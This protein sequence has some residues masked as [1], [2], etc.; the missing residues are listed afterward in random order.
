MKPIITATVPT[1]YQLRSLSAFGI[2][3]KKNG[4]G[5]YSGKMESDSREE[6]ASLHFVEPG[7]H[8]RRAYSGSTDAGESLRTMQMEAEAKQRR[9]NPENRTSAIGSAVDGAI[10]GE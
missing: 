1:G 9:R 3:C 4:D 5:S 6:T 8:E 10:E 2:G 7:T